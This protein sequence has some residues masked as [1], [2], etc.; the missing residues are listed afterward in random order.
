MHLQIKQGYGYLLVTELSETMF[1]L[2]VSGLCTLPQLLQHLQKRPRTL[3][4]HQL[5]GNKAVL[6]LCVKLADSYL[7]LASAQLPLNFL[8]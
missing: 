7:F 5:N 1:K 6:F 4:Q 3:K 8:S 2:I